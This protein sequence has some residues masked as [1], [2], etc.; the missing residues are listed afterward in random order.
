MFIDIDAYT[1][2]LGILATCSAQL[3]TYY[4]LLAIY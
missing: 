4:I 3:M 2:L 1:M